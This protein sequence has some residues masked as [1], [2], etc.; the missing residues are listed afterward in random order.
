[1]IELL[2]SLFEA[3]PEILILGFGKEGRSTYNFIRKYFVNQ[4]L[5][6][7]DS[8]P[9]IAKKEFLIFDE[10]TKID[11]GDNYLDNLHNYDLIIKSPG[12]KISKIDNKLKKTITSQTDLFLRYFH[13]NTIGVTGTKGKSTTSS[14]IK[15]FSEADNKKVILLGNI[16]VPAFN[17]IENINSDTIVVYELSA[18][19]LEFTHKSP[20][21]AILINIFPEH[22]DYFESF[23]LYKNAKLNICK[24]QNENDCLI[25][26]GSL[27]DS[28]KKINSKI[29]NISILPYEKPVYNIKNNPLLGIHN[30]TNINMALSAAEC[31]N[32]DTDVAINSLSNFSTL[33]HRLEYIGEYGKIKF[34]NDSISTVPES[35][36]AAVSALQNIDTIIL[37][38]YDRG[39]DYNLLID[40]LEDSTISNFILL[41]KAGDRMHD[42]FMMKNT[43]KNLLK[44]TSLQSAFKHSIGKTKKGAICLLSPSAASYDQFNNFEQR[45]NLFSMLA[46][47]YKGDF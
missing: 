2:K 38:G 8:N 36:M 11:A 15:H 25:T 42:I 35:T 21:V 3:N 18:H 26:I 44:E 14:L 27:I 13:E 46:Q 17:Q 34:V 7:G 24:F 6:I 20:H 9:N 41:G 10:N 31:F 30:L 12:V 29:K 16:G 33:P 4:R 43:R 28:V 19:Q 40:F 45:G 39:L 23:D 47:E 37:G 32:V 5:V 22:L 1:M